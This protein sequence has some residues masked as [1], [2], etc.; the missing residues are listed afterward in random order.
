M[1]FLILFLLVWIIFSGTR[2]AKTS[3]KNELQAA[4]FVLAI[5]L[6]AVTSY[7]AGNNLS[8]YA[9]TILYPIWLLPQF[10]VDEHILTT[11]TGPIEELLYSIKNIMRGM[12]MVMSW[13][14]DISIF[15]IIF[16]LF[17]INYSNMYRKLR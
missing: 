16:S 15:Y 9:M 2:K 17:D 6:I 13:I 8:D 1:D 11:Q 10:F 3:L 5:I 4:V 7:Y 14:I 12:L